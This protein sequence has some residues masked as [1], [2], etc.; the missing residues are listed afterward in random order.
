MEVAVLE[1]TLQILHALLAIGLVVAVIL[2][3][4]REAGMP[5]I[6]GG[7]NLFGKTKGIEEKLSKVT[8]AI[9]ILFMIS[10]VVLAFIVGR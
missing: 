1:L 8:S 5:G 10:S 6:I 3:P 2:Q 4:S 7:Q 9:A